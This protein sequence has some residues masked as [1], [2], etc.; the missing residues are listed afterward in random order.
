MRCPWSS[1]RNNSGITLSVCCF[2]V[3]AGVRRMLSPL[4]VH[5]FLL[6]FMGLVSFGNLFHSQMWRKT[7]RALKIPQTAGSSCPVLHHGEEGE[8]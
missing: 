4:G 5:L 1:S 3:L 7:I 6:V 2:L 8:V